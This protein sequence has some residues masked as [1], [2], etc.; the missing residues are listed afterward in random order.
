MTRTITL[1]LATVASMAAIAATAP[2]AS[3]AAPVP[4]PV[5][6]VMPLGDSIT[7]GYRSSTDAGYRG[8]LADLVARQSRYAVDLVGSNHNGAVADPDNEGHS[9]YVVNDVAA[10]IDGWLAAAQP[11]V[12]LLHIGIND[13][14]RGTDKAH[15]ADRASALIDRIL[16]DRSG[17]SVLVMGLIPTT[18]DLTAQVADYN[19]ALSQAVRAK[20][21]QGRKVR[22]TAAPALTPAEMADGLHPDDLGYQ[23]MAQTFD[24]ALDLAFTDGLA[25]PAPAHRAGTES[26]GSGRVRWADFDGDGRADYVIVNDD[27]SVRVFSNKGGDG[28][29][30]WSDLGQVASGMTGDRARVRFAD[31][32]GDG[33]ADYLVINADGSVRV[34]SNKGGDG[35]GGWTDLGQVASGMTADPAQVAFADFDGDGRT[36]YTT[37]ADDG[38]VHVFLNRGGDGRGGWSDLGKVAGGLTTDR[39]RLRLADFD[40]DGRADY[41]VVNPDGS[42]T[43]FL[44]KGGDGHGG[45]TDHGRTAAGL[46]T[47]QNSVALADVNADAH[48]DYLVTTGPTTA[49]LNNGGDGWNTPGW[50]DY[51]QIATGA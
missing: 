47:D 48:A 38:A 51:G 17:V 10:G 50:I 20:Q 40:G 28:H 44:N 23:R 12:V 34:F 41:N 7:A 1:A 19:T 27:G 36:D 11:D 6:R 42:L 22:Y 45:W 39:S 30:G 26:G 15:A 33:R 46:T 32:D 31:Y 2:A 14:D 4:A 18:P 49:F 43:T 9:G 21:D 35:H 24:Q 37:I 16:A 8:P 5:L 25:V 29:G 3:A 13:L